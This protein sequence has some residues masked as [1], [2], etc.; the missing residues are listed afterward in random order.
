MSGRVSSKLPH[1]INPGQIQSAVDTADPARSESRWPLP[2]R[3][4]AERGP[5]TVRMKRHLTR[6]RSRRASG[7]HRARRRQDRACGGLNR[8]G[9]DGG[10]ARRRFRSAGRD[11]KM[12]R[13][14]QKMGWEDE[15]E[16]H[17]QL[18]ILGGLTRPRIVPLW[19]P[20]SASETWQIKTRPCVR[21]PRGWR[22]RGS[23][24]SGNSPAKDEKKTA[25]RYQSRVVAEHE[26][27]RS[28]ERAGFITSPSFCNSPRIRNSS[29]GSCFG[30]S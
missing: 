19:K 26:C 21:S 14:N 15:P 22:V 4:P 25:T 1:A 17:G 6:L 11:E 18:P 12:S 23:L 13:P 5:V 2:I 27:A 28:T 29:E 24:C 8:A 20:A 16:T 3:A 7:C 9:L 30:L 10:C